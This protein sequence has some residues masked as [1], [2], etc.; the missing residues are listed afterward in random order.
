ML[1]ISFAYNKYK[2][3]GN[4]FL[5]WLW[6]LIENEKDLAPYLTIKEK[7]SLNIGNGICLE[8]HLGDQST[9]KITIRGDQ[10]GLE[11]GT[12]ALKKGAYVIQINLLCTIGEEEYIFTIKGESLNVTGLKTP[13]IGKT[14]GKDDREGAVLEKI[15]L[16]VKV[17]QVIDSLFLNY[18]S[19][20]SS[21]EWK[22]SQLNEIRN[23]ISG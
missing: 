18:L 17:F 12:T 14:S 19:L 4:E 5:T 11:E 13:A 10:A 23:W 1:D 8:N 7:V 16:Y 15:Y 3:L 9:E 21:D 2:F 22:R 20:R 6:F